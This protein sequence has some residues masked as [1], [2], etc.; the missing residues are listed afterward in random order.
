ML[1]AGHVGH[2]I[3]SAFLQ[4][5]ERFGVAALGHRN[6]GVGRFVAV[7]PGERV[8]L[9]DEPGGGNFDA[10]FGVE[11]GEDGEGG[12]RAHGIV[13]DAVVGVLDGVL[14]IVDNERLASSVGDDIGG[15]GAFSFIDAVA[16]DVAEGLQVFVGEG[17]KL[18]LHVARRAVLHEAM[19]AGEILLGL[20]G[21]DGDLQLL[22]ELVPGVDDGFGQ[23]DGFVGGRG[24][25]LEYGPAALEDADVENRRAGFVAADGFELGADDAIDGL[26]LLLHV[27]LGTGEGVALLRF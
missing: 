14:E 23:M 9:L 12:K 18:L 25:V 15:N 4:Q 7:A 24:V 17:G 10:A 26:H 21:A 27:A 22:H 20:A 8:Q 1:P 5:G 19:A 11:A 6:E 3:E 16:E 13:A 2:G